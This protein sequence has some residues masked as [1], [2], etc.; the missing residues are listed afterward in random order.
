VDDFLTE[1]IGPI[2]LAAGEAG[3]AT[4]AVRV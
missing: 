4:E 2:L 3:L 1:V